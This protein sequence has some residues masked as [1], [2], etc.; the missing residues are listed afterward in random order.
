MPHF[1]SGLSVYTAAG[2]VRFF[3]V[4]TFTMWLT[5]SPST[6]SFHRTSVFDPGTHCSMHPCCQFHAF[7]APSSTHRSPSPVSTIPTR[8]SSSARGDRPSNRTWFPSTYR[9]VG[10]NCSLS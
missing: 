3:P 6:R 4:F 7:V 1:P 9:P 10:S 5:N 2:I 8:I